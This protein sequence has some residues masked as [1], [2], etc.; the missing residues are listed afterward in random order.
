MVQIDKLENYRQNLVS[1]GDQI[2][3]LKGIKRSTVSVKMVNDARFLDKLEAGKTCTVDSYNNAV[4]WLRDNWP[5]SK[6]Q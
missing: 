4:Q 5:E 2:A 3:A 6:A 1:S